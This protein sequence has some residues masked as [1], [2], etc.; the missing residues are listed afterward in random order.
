LSKNY[1]FSGLD[2][3]QMR[4]SSI[5]SSLW[6]NHTKNVPCELL[7]NG[8]TMTRA[9]LMRHALNAGTP[10]GA[11]RLLI[12]NEEAVLVGGLFHLPAAKDL[13]FVASRF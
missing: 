5:H 13:L 11:R 6:N 12:A 7:A 8:T 9:E 2:D 4:G 10:R 3:Y 1:L